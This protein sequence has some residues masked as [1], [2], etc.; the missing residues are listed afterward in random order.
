MKHSSRSAAF[1]QDSFDFRRK[2]KAIDY[3][4][5]IFCLLC[6]SA[7]PYLWC[8]LLMGLY[9][10]QRD[11]A[12]FGCRLFLPGIHDFIPPWELPLAD[13][14]ISTKTQ[15][16]FRLP[17]PTPDEIKAIERGENPGRINIVLI[18][19][20]LLI[21]NIEIPEPVELEEMGELDANF[22]SFEEEY[23]CELTPDA[24]FM[25]Y[26]FD[27]E[28]IAINIEDVKEQVQ[29]P[30]RRK[31]NIPKGTLVVRI[32]IDKRGNYKK[33]QIL[34]P[35]HPICVRSVEK[36]VHLIRFTPAIQGGRPIETWIIVPFHFSEL[37]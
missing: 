35:L 3:Q 14:S 17:R 9:P 33:H 16:T 31:S 23:I 7:G 5:L 36:H 15:L 8:K 24:S 29:F 25:G 18:D 30:F 6:F 12:R 27:Q 28:P 1:D 20:M 11:E 37:D 13:T 26:S 34:K 22:V 21:E 32:L 4:L 10:E 2:I 19:S